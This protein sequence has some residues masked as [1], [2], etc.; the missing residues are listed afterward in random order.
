MPL[1]PQC[2]AII[3]AAAQAGAPFDAGDHIAVRAGY[4]ATT[5]VYRHET[6]ALDSVANLMFEGPAGNIPVRVYRPR[7][8][9]RAPLPAL[10][11]FHGGGWVVGDLET[12]DHM[13]RYLA[14]H[15]D[16]VV[17]SV[18]YRLAP[19]HKFPA[20]YDDA[21]AAMRWVMSAPDDLNVDADRLAI[22]GD[23]AGGN[24]SAAVTLALRD[25]GIPALKLQLLIYPVMDF[26]ADNDSIRDYTTGYMLTKAAMDMFTDWYLPDDGARADPRASPQQAADHAGLPPAFVQTAEYDMLRDE[27]RR[28]ADTLEQAGIAVEYRCY[29][30]MIHGFMRMGSKIDTAITALDDA[31]DALRRALA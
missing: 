16:V 25:A 26:L 27:G 9:G 3:D 5:P 11:F 29:P 30:G 21:L 1:D 7:V 6:P 18:D 12:H 13:C 24:L 28:Y 17:A 10:V 4:A 23:S 19:E 20:A 31:V 22:G 8:E 2:Q 14:G 15:G